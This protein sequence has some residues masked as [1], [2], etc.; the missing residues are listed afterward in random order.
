MM[1]TFSY[2]Q[3]CFYI[4]LAALRLK[5][6]SEPTYLTGKTFT[7]VQCRVPS[8]NNGEVTPT[9]NAFDVDE[10][11]TFTCNEGFN[12]RGE[13]VLECGEDGEWSDNFPVCDRKLQI[14]T[15]EKLG[16]V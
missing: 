13:R 5:S 16:Q 9:K 8:I 11:A 15:F 4:T 14:K 10:K 12:L 7:A 6:I 3:F 2:S 1:R